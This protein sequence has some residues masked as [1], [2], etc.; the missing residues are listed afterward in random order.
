MGQKIHPKLF[1][2]GQ[3]STWVSRWF[4]M[5]N[6]SVY[7]LQDYRIR[8]AINARFPKSGI[9]DIDIERFG[10]EIKVTIHSSRPGVII[11]RGGAGI[12]A[13]KKALKKNVTKEK[14]EIEIKEVRNPESNAAVVAGGIA[15]QIERRLPFRRAAKQA[16]EAAKQAR[17]QGI[18]ISISGRLN[19]ADIARREIFNYG[20]V[21]LHTIKQPVDYA[22]RTAATTYG[23]IGIKVWVLPAKDAPTEEE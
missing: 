12:E 16:V 1:R 15:E 19:G 23:T 13:V 10:A 22:L 21:P 9:S 3:T 20:K 18:R 17:V 14:L 5:K 4:D 11:G 6:Y 8:E 7:L 2:L